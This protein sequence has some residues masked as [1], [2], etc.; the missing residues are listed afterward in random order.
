MVDRHSRIVGEGAPAHDT[1]APPPTPTLPCCRQRGGGTVDETVMMRHLLEG[2]P[3]TVSEAATSSAEAREYLRDHPETRLVLLDDGL[4][5]LPL[6]RCGAVPQRPAAGQGWL[7]TG[8]LAGWLA[9]WAGHRIHTSGPEPVLL[10]LLL[11]RLSNCPLLL[12]TVSRFALPL[13]SLSTALPGRDLEI[14]MVN[15]LSPFG[16]GHLLPRCAGGGAGAGWGRV[17]RRPT[18]VG[19]QPAAAAAHACM[20][21]LPPAAAAT[22]YHCCLDCTRSSTIR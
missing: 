20:P 5:H 17:L 1:L 21:A 8:R 7:A 6:V 10:L 12:L 9:R 11:L 13:P 14:V 22:P 3:V 18:A 2:L 19:R 15:S 16:N 4:Q